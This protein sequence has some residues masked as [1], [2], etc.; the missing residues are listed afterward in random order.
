[1]DCR[2]GLA[3]GT[4]FITLLACATEAYSCKT[5]KPVS[6]ADMVREAD[7]I[8]RAS[9]ENYAVP[10]K[11]PISQT[12]FD[13]DSG[14]RIHFR[15]LEVIKG[16]TVADVVLPGTLVDIDDFNDQPSPYALVRPDGRKGSCFATSYRSGGQ[17]LLMLKERHD[18]GFTITWYPLAPVNEQLHSLSDP[19]LSWIRKQAIAIAHNAELAR[20]RRL[21]RA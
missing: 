4:A 11:A 12:G 9:A 18:G 20:C 21:H 13:V 6:N 19:W 3:V 17:F 15:V 5:A 7:V 16:K 8:V 2:F 10:P 14:S 1:M